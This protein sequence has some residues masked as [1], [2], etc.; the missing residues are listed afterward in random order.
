M[1]S[2]VFSNNSK[3]LASGSENGSVRLWDVSDVASRTLKH[4]NPRIGVRTV[5]HN[6]CSP[7][8]MMI[9]VCIYVPVCRLHMLS[10]YVPSGMPSQ[11]C[12]V[13]IRNG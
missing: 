8:V 10:G 6:I 13:P 7:P 5:E 2:L 12:H 9:D 11:R 1:F 4:A 3:M